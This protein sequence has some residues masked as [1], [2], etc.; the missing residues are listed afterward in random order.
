MMWSAPG[1]ARSVSA[2][3]RDDSPEVRLADAPRRSTRATRS[4][5]RSSRL[6]L[7]R[8]RRAASPAGGAAAIRPLREPQD[9]GVR[10]RRPTS[11]TSWSRRPGSRRCC[12][13]PACAG[14]RR[15][16][17]AS[18]RRAT[19]RSTTRRFLTWRRR[20][21]LD[22]RVVGR[23]L[24]AAVPAQVLVAAVAVRPRRSPR[25]A[26][27]SYETRS[28]SVK[29]SWQVTKLTLACG[30]RSLVA[31]DVRAAEEPL[32]DGPDLARVA[33]DERAHVVAEAAVPLDPA[34]ADEAADLV[35]P[36]GVPRLGDELRAGQDRVGL[37][38]PEDRRIGQRLGRPRRATGP[39]RGR[40]GS[41]RRASPRPSSGG[42]RG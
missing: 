33:L 25:C 24:D 6:R 15:P 3:L 36:A 4:R 19:S 10:A 11:R 5:R 26:C 2:T 23:A 18:G 13:R 35:Q 27:A 21:A 42:C 37:D 12:C 22:R 8:A 7:A 1:P 32:R 40:S 34:V 28:L 9:V 17:A 20:S 38:V 30:S 16:S 31:V 41:R 29:P 14:P 39:T